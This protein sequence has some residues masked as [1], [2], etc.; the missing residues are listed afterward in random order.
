MLINISMLALI[1]DHVTLILIKSMSADC[2][3]MS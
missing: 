2:Q 1:A 3:M